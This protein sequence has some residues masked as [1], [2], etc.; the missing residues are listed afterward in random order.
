MSK[1]FS[2]TGMAFVALAV[3]ATNGYCAKMY[4]VTGKVIST[5]NDTVTIQRGDDQFEFDRAQ[6]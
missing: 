2:L 1:Y 3:T 4:Q 5:T 6:A